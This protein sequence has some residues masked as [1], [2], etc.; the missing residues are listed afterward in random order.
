MTDLH[1]DMTGLDLHD[2]KI[3]Y[4]GGVPATIPD[5]AGRVYVQYDPTY[6][7]SFFALWIATDTVSTGDWKCLCSFGQLT[8][9]IVSSAP[10]TPLS[11]WDVRVNPITGKLFVAMN[12]SASGWYEIAMTAIGFTGGGG[13]T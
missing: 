12:D 13:G 5:V 2:S 8:T 3:P 1:K 11:P 6:S 10:P 9:D 4:G 7:S